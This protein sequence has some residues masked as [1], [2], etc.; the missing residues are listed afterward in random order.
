MSTRSEELLD[1]VAA[2]ADRLADSDKLADTGSMAT[3]EALAELYE[4]REWVEEW[5]EQSP[6]R[7]K[8]SY[9]GGQVP[10]PDNRNRFAAWLTWAEDQRNRKA[11]V[12]QVTDRLL[13]AHEIVAATRGY[14]DSEKTVR[15]LRWL[16]TNR[17]I[18]RIAEVWK[19]AVELAGSEDLVTSAHTKQALAEWK[20]DVLGTKGMQ[21]VKGSAKA[22]RD[23]AKAQ[24]AIEDLL[25][26][27]DQSEFDAFHDWYVALIRKQAEREAAG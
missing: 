20:K 26:D 6:I 11:P 14:S 13:V 15:P 3:A 18:D 9:V 7:E 19:R 10:Q 16:K 12:R 1:E 23:R 27:G 8:K 4:K 2:Y 25:A 22:A 17:F 5:L 21:T 24:A